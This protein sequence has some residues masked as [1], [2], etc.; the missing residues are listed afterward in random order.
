[1]SRSAP[2]LLPLVQG[3]FQDHLRSVRGAS[4]HTIRAYRDALRLFFLFTAE[5]EHRSVAHLQLDDIRSDVVLAFLEHLEGVRANKIATRNGRLSAIHSFVA[6]LLRHDLTRAEQYRQ[7]L[8]IPTKRALIKPPNYLEPAEARAL[9]AQAKPETASGVRD[10]ALL[11]FLYNTGARVSE[12]LAVKIQDLQLARPR[13]VRLHGKGGKDRL[14]P[15]WPETASALRTHLEHANTLTQGGGEVFRNARG[16][17]LTRDGVAYL[18]AKYVSRASK[19]TPSLR[20]R[21]VTPHTLRHGCAVALL[22]AGVEL[23]VIRDYLGHVSVA[24][25]GRYLSSNLEMKRKVLAAFWKRAGLSSPPHR[26]WR[27]TA[28]ILAFLASL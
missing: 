18:L 8:A 14:C 27:P 19:G 6:H 25:T 9:I 3:Y 2:S 4:A 1:M 12:A 15:L 26:R 22:Q 23:S 11:L 13:L 17:P 24:T 21:R 7:I 16:F 5:H 28:S 10:L 20:N